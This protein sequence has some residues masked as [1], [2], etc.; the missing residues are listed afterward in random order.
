MDLWQCE[1][2]KNVGA[3][4]YSPIPLTAELLEGVDWEGYV[5]FHFNSYFSIDD[6]GHFFYHNDYTGINID[7]LHQLQ[8]M[9]FAIT[10][11]E[12]SI[13]T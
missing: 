5:K 2:A 8:N 12:L 11:K 6:V 13:T 7:Y 10:G 9:Y 4:R 1:Q 3:F